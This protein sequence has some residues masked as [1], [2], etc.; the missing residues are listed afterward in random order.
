M[1]L[2]FGK[3]S[4]LGGFSL[5]WQSEQAGATKRLEKIRQAAETAIKAFI[6]KE[7][8]KFVKQARKRVPVRTGDLQRS[9]RS[10]MWNDGLGYF[11]TAYKLGT[12]RRRKAP[13]NYGEY[14]EFS[15]FGTPFMRPTFKTRSRFLKKKTVKIYKDLIA[16]YKV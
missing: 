3:P 15:T 6:E 11:A 1:A 13:F 16:K 14:V 4:A 8:P 2:K 5:R 10:N 9:I 7:G 12:G